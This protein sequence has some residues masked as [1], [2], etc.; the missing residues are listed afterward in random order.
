MIDFFISYARE[1]GPFARELVE[2]LTSLD[3]NVWI[4]EKDIP[5]S[6]PWMTE[7]KHAIDESMMVVALESSHWNTSDACQIEVK[8]AEQGRVPIHHITP[9]QDPLEQIVEQ[10]T[11][12]YQGLP[13][14][15]PIALQAAASASIWETAGRKKSLLVRGRP[16]TAMRKSLSQNPE[17]FS[18]SATAFIRFCRQRAIRRWVAG[19]AFGLVAPILGLGILTS[20]Q[21]TEKVNEKVA[22]NIADATFAAEQRTYADWNVYSGIER[23]TQDAVNTY[24]GYVQLFSF[25]SDQTPIQW[26]SAAV[27]E[28]GPKSAKSPDGIKTAT[29]HGAG[30]I[31][32]TAKGETRKLLTSAAAT[33]LAWSP[34]SRW[35]AVTTAKGADIVSVENTQVIPLRGGVGTTNNVRWVGSQRVAV[36]GTAGT[37]TWQVF[38]GVPVA[39]LDGVRYGT[40]VGND[41]YTVNA[42]G[43][44]S[45]TNTESGSSEV[46][47]WERPPNATPTSM[48][49][50]GTQVAIAFDADIPF[51]HVFDASSGSSR[52]ISMP[53][54][55]PIGLSLSPDG[56]SAYLTCLST[57]VNQSRV[58]LN[59]GTVSS[60][61]VQHQAVYGVRALQ[62]RVLWGGIYGGVF[63]SSLDLTPKGLLT[64]N[65]G[66]NAPIR[67]FVG[68][69]DGATFFQIGDATGSFGCA[70]RIKIGDE[71]KVNRLVLDPTD[72]HAVPDAATSPDGSLIAYGLSD[73]RIRVLTAS[74]F[75]PVYFAQVLSSQVRAVFFSPDGSTLFVAGLDGAIVALPIADDAGVEGAA[76][77]FDNAVSKLQNAV[78]WGIYQPTMDLAPKEGE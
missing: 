56:N 48:D 34:D 67:K 51:L 37:G 5:P 4:D 15:R 43:T 53:E 41:L 73:G 74:N 28:Q 16:L 61:P 3:W 6:V 36:A 38:D 13:E 8:L 70:S 63:E 9:G 29:V 54:C 58:D 69:A 30:I 75:Y 32:T 23:T 18:P 7:I 21:L 25:L 27:L 78:N 24:I 20:L 65:A 52:D 77:L 55:S 10:V 12:A 17:D 31:V 2:R 72:G 68:Q 44:I 40:T 39:S 62:D 26:D 42:E 59:T 47:A 71:V 22:K 50:Q 14:W 60:M 1:D 35:L 33:S 66:C 76:P 11:H 45:K 57:A 46:L 49:S 19:I 64:S